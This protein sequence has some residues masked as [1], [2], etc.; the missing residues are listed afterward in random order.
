MLIKELAAEI[1]QNAVEHGWWD[2]NMRYAEAIA[3]I[4]SEW[5]E[6]LE[7][8]RNGKPLVYRVCLEDPEEADVCNPKDKSECMMA[9][10]ET[11]CKYY[12]KKPEGIAV[13]LIDGC[14]RILDYLA[15]CGHFLTQETEDKRRAGLSADRFYMQEDAVPPKDFPELISDLHAITSDAYRKGSGHLERACGM[16]MRWVAKQG[17]DPVKLMIE[18]HT[19]NKTRPYKHGKKF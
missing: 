1:H 10:R 19:Y 7:E 15:R 18:K 14:I 3:L 17:I 11:E 4:H 9:G 5:S 16:A 8:A 13:E 12:G 6:A 2:G